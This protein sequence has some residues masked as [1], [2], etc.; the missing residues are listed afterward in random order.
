MCVFVCVRA[1]ICACTTEQDHNAFLSEALA[2]LPKADKKASQPLSWRCKRI[3]SSWLLAETGLPKSMPWSPTVGQ[4]SNQEQGT[5]RK[6]SRLLDI[7][8]FDDQ[9]YQQVS[10]KCRKIL[11]WLAAN[12]QN[13]RI[14]IQILKSE[15]FEDANRSKP[16]KP[17]LAESWE[18]CKL[19]GAAFP[20]SKPSVSV[21]PSKAS[22]PAQVQHECI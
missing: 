7:D 2:L 5:K 1:H 15:E 4:A 18:W 9:R 17:L 6:S 13:K 10:R 12:R 14:S 19:L 20:K 16:T 3:R 22:G 11:D 21:N 8:R